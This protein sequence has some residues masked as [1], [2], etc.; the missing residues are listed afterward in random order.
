MSTALDRPIGTPEQYRGP[1]VA[2]PQN[3][4]GQEPVSMMASS[5]SM[6]SSIS[7]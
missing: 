6:T 4:V 2:G 3:A 5:A 1:E 7:A